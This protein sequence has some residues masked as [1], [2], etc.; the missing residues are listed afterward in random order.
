MKLTSRIDKLEASTNGTDSPH[1]IY[2]N[3][4]APPIAGAPESGPHRIECCG[5]E[6]I[7]RK[8]ETVCEFENRA[9]SEALAQAR[10]RGIAV[11]CMVTE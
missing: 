11:V 3:M 6:W 4:I 5:Q 9:K 10:G 1:L 8:G 7:R 2:V